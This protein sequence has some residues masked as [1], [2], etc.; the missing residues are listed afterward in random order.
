MKF[1][2][3]NEVNMLLMVYKTIDIVLI[4]L[5]RKYKTK[6][7]FRSEGDLWIIINHE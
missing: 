6:A 3:N 7:P 5:E 2:K 1:V 4:P